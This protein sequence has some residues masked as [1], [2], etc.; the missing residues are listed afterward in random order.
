M[1]GNIPT[2]A[3]ETHMHTQPAQ[4]KLEMCLLG[5]FYL[6]IGGKQPGGAAQRLLALLAVYGEPLSRRQAAQALWPLITEARANANLRS[7]LWRLSRSC[8]NAFE[9]AHDKLKLNPTISVDL[10]QATQVAER[11]ADCSRPLTRDELSRAL[12][13]NLSEDILP[14]WSE[15]DYWLITARERFHQL[16]LHALEGLCEQLTQAGWY[17]AAVD[18]GLAAVQSEPLRESAHRV[19]ITAYLAEGNAREALRQHQHCRQLLHQ[20]LDLHPS[21]VLPDL[22]DQDRSDSRLSSSMSSM[23]VPLEQ[24]PSL[25]QTRTTT[26]QA[27]A[28]FYRVLADPTRLAIISYLLRAPHTVTELVARL[29][30]SQSRISN[31]LACLRWC[32]FVNAERQGRQVV[33]SIGDPRLRQLLDITDELVAENFDHL[34]TCQRIGPDW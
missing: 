26:Y 18:V 34:S 17:G 14:N 24:Q 21:E 13:A 19:L 20:E 28:R 27:D 32:K 6:N 7:T 8:P 22:L 15:E 23:S 10:H 30:V 2:G 31:H 1:N 9:I 25:P 3:R 16:R 12:Q 11:L 4:P 5:Q 29:K 33:Y